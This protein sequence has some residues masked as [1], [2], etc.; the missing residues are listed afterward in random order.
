REF[1]LRD[2]EGRYW[3]APAVPTGRRITLR[4]DPAGSSPVPD[5]TGNGTS[6]LTGLIK[7]AW[8]LTEPWQWSALGAK[9]EFAPIGTL[10]S[11]RWQ[12]DPVVY[13]GYA[14]RAATANR[15]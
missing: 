13:A 1:R 4:P 6:N 10:R 12:D 5:P 7:E 8:T 11:I 14:E 9:T 3:I 2:P 15:P